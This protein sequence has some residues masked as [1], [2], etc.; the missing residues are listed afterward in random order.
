MNL[1]GQLTFL[2]LKDVVL[3]LSE[4]GAGLC[5]DEWGLA[6]GGVLVLPLNADKQYK[7]LLRSFSGLAKKISPRPGFA[8]FLISFFH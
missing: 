1:G 8:I 5:V 4:G 3:I 7:P 6:G 2:F